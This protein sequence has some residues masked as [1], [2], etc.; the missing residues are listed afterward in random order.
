M[1]RRIAALA[2]AAAMILTLCG[3]GVLAAE[4]QD[5]ETGETAQDPAGTVT[6]TNLERRLR[7]NNSNLLSLEETIAA[8][9]STNYE[10]LKDT[11]RDGL[12]GIAEAQWQ[13][14]SMSS[15][16]PGGALATSSTMESL[17]QTY[18]GLRDTFDDLKEGKLQAEHADLVRQLRSAQDQM[19]MGAN[20]LYIT[21]VSLENTQVT[22]DRGLATLDRTIEEMELRHRLGQISAL[23]LQDVKNN[24]TALESSRQ[25]L[26]TNIRNCKMQLELMIG[27]EL[28]GSIRLG[29]LPEV[30]AAQLAEMDLEADLE[31]YLAA[32]YDLYAAKKT[33]DDA[34]ED[35]K[36]AQKK[37][38]YNTAWYEYQAAEHTVKAARYTYTSTV[39]GA[40]LRF[41]TLYYQVKDNAQVLE[42]ARA[43]LAGK[44]ADCAAMELKYSQGTISQ[45]QLLTA[46]DEVEEARDKVVSAALDLFTNYNNYRWAVDHGI[47]NG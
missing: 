34:E 44:E 41:R 6:Y 7:E 9:Q 39:Q 2:L 22:V 23:T 13:L 45:N 24:R 4:D 30:T 10:A 18:D 1:K 26:L 21:L 12:N 15:L 16:I 11:L 25:T 14:I 5:T 42:A 40:E 35:F 47:L 27:A 31:T 8:I 37:H 46:R 32:S 36:D 20:A 19:V 38:G 28:T 33:L 3:A 17:Q 29:D 43:A